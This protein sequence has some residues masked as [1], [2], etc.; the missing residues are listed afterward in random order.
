MEKERTELLNSIAA[1]LQF[2][3]DLE[4]KTLSLLQKSQG[5]QE[6]NYAPNLHSHQV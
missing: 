5:K 4:D 6:K 1:D 2:L 3:R